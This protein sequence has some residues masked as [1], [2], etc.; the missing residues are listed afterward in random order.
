M[1]P[2]A[3]NYYRPDTVDDVIGLL[4]EWGDDA[5]VIA[6]GHSLIPVMKQRLSDISHLIDLGGVEALKGIII[7]GGTVTIG[8]MT[9]QHELITNDAL[10][11]AA[12]IIREASLQIADPQVRYLGTIGGNVANGDPAN[13]MPGLMQT[14]GATYHL[15]GPNG[16]RTVAARDFYEAAYFTAREDDEILTAVS[17]AATSGGYAYEKQKRKIGDYATAA[18]GVLLTMHGGS[19]SA[20]SV[21]LTNLSDTPVYCT[22]A[23]DILVGSSVDDEAVA[24]AVKAAVDVSDPVADT[25]GPVDFKKYVA[26]VIVKKAIESARSRA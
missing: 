12:P 10:A 7:D 23:V 2:G 13:D 16:G 15:A 8:A 5:R 17:F 18:A 6:G 9:T 4:G 22:G 24:A 21:A 20:A 26:G 3:F 1:V 14:L 11:S 19:C 25:R